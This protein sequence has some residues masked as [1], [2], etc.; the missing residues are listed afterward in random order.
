VP[1][2]IISGD[3]FFVEVDGELKQTRM[4]FRHFTGSLKGREP[5]GQAGEYYSADGYELKKGL[6]AVFGVE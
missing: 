3:H 4:Q 6:R 2:E 5:F 1:F